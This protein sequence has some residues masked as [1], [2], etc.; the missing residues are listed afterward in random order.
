VARVVLETL[1]REAMIEASRDKGER[2]LKE[3]TAALEGHPRVGD[4]RG[5]GLMV[6]VELVEDRATRSPFPREGM[7]AERVVAASKAQGLL[8]YS[9]TG[10][11]DGT[12]GDLIMFGPPFVISNEEITEAVEKTQVALSTLQ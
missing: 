11:A 2:L 12:D 9:S 3:L 7:V 5:L 10:C 8:L 4:I 6:G 1:R